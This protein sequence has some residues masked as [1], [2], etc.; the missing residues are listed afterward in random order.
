MN[1]TTE[2]QRPRMVEDIPE[3][4]RGHDGNIKDYARDEVRIRT[5]VLCY[6]NHDLGPVS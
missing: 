1:D 3:N 2:K 4:D 5:R 6:C